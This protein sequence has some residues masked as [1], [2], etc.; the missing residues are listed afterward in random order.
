MGPSVVEETYAGIEVGSKKAGFVAFHLSSGVLGLMPNVYT[1]LGQLLPG[2][3]RGRSFYVWGN[4]KVVRFN[5]TV[6]DPTYGQQYAHI[7][8]MAHFTVVDWE[9][10]GGGKPATMAQF[11]TEGPQCAHGRYLLICET[12]DKTRYYFR[13]TPASLVGA[14]LLYQ[15]PFTQSQRDWLGFFASSCGWTD[16]PGARHH[17]LDTRRSARLGALAGNCP[18]PVYGI[19]Q[20]PR[21]CLKAFREAAAGRIAVPDLAN[22]GRVPGG[23]R[24]GPSRTD[25]QAIISQPQKVAKNLGWRPTSTRAW[26]PSAPIKSSPSLEAE[27]RG[28]EGRAPRVRDFAPGRM[29]L[30][31]CSP[32]QD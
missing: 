29:E 22:P 8:D 10:L 30:P 7:T 32:E 11:D 14:E 28:S 18:R 25:L 13:M 1:K 5:R 24:V 12:G 6:F 16:P 31:Q 23:R 21:A 3:M 20:G 15:G 26:N 9:K 27:G 19:V 2:S 4:H 17:R